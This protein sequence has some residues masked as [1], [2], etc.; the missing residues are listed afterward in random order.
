MAIKIEKPITVYIDESRQGNAGSYAFS[1]TG[2]VATF[3]AWNALANEWNGILRHY[4]LPYFHT[5]DFVNR[6]GVFSDVNRWSDCKFEEC[7][8]R[9]AQT[10]SEHTMLGLGC[11]IRER[12]YDEAMPNEGKSWWK[13]PYGFCLYT[14][15]AMLMHIEEESRLTLPPKPLH[16]MFDSNPEFEPTVRKIYRSLRLNPDEEAILAEKPSFDDDKQYPQLQAADLLVWET[17]KEQIHLDK[18]TKPKIPEIMSKIMS[19]LKRRQ[20]VV[21][22]KPT[23]EKIQRYVE[24]LQNSDRQ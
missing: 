6:K 19:M 9:F 23:K 13:S 24:F 14:V 3:D 21:I 20:N 4:G 1:V 18:K 15:L 16:F 10:A 11:A 5:T 8:L 17:T 7:L 12:D 22:A 2:Y